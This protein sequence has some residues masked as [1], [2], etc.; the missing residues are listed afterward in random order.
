MP[1]TLAA[2]IQQ[3]AGGKSVA[4]IFAQSQAL[5]GQ[6]IMVK[7]QVTRFAANIMGRNWLHIS[8]GTGTT[9]SNDLTVTTAD[10]AAVGDIVT[11][12]GQVA[13]KQDFG[14]GYAYDVLI[15]KAAVQK[16]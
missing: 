9:G 6:E 12:R 4:E 11:V 15:E 14:F 8:D 7:G 3:P 10:L 16:N 1:A 2:P 13:V 5:K